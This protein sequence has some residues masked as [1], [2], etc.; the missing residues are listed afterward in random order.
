VRNVG[1]RRILTSFAEDVQLL[2]E[3]S[4]QRLIE[5]LSDNDDIPSANTVWPCGAP[6][7]NG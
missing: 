2:P 3:K 1:S 6:A 5:S 7:V 4:W